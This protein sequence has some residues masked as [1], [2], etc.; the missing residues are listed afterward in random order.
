[1]IMNKKLCLS[2]KNKVIAGVCGGFAEY[3]GVDAT[4]VRI[5]LVILIL[6]FNV[7]PMPIV[8]YI[9]CWAVMPQQ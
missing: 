3:F 7:I 1:M 2:R 4:L 8:L 9:I 5:I 6:V